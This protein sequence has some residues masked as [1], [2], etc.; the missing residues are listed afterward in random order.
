MQST[1]CRN[2]NEINILSR[3]EKEERNK[4][5]TLRVYVPNL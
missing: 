1:V 4:S 3:G 5:T 2:E